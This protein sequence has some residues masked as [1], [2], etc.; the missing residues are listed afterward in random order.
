MDR[1]SSSLPC[2]PLVP[3]LKHET[4]FATLCSLHSFKMF[5]FMAMLY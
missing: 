4:S 1:H 3:D 2:S 5:S